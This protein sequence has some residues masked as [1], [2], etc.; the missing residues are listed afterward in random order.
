MR[1]HDGQYRAAARVGDAE[2]AAL[3]G[4]G[5]GERHGAP[6]RGVKALMLALLEDAIRAYLGPVPQRREEAAFWLHDSRRHWVF[7]FSVVCESLGL[8][9]SAVRAAV[10]RMANRAAVIR[11]SALGRSRPNSRRQAGLR[12]AARLAPSGSTAE[13]AG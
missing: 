8:E 5:G 2:I 1:D 10:R 7:S 9:P 6:Y 13:L 12:I 4:V 11:P 3:V